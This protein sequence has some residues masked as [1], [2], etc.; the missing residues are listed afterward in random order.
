MCRVLGFMVDV[1]VGLGR[2]VGKV[3]G[4]RSPVEVK[5]PFGFTAA[6][7]PK[8]HVHGFH[9][10]SNDGFDVNTQGSGVVSFDW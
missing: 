1:R 8:A 4:A 2:V 9:F 10:L 5:L 6:K 7:P 3:G